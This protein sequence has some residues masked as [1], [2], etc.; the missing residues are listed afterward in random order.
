LYFVSI[1]LVFFMLNMEEE[2]EEKVVKRGRGRPRKEKVPESKTESKKVVLEVKA[3]EGVNVNVENAENKPEERAGAKDEK[4]ESKPKPKSKG[5]PKKK[6]GKKPRK[7]RQFRL[8]SRKVFLTY[9]KCF[10]SIDTVTDHL[11][12]L[13]QRYGI[14]GYIIAK[15][16][17]EDGSPHYHAL[18]SLFKKV[19][20]KRPDFFDLVSEEVLGMFKNTE[21]GNDEYTYKSVDYHGEYQG[22]KSEKDTLD[23]ITKE[24]FTAEETVDCLR[25]NEYYSKMMGGLYNYISLPK[26]MI[27]LAEQGKIDRAMSLLKT[28]DSEQ[29]LK[30]GSVIER[31]LMSIYLQTLGGVSK[32]PLSSFQGSPQFRSFIS[33]YE[34]GVRL[35]CPRFLIIKGPAGCGKSQFIR[36]FFEQHYGLRVFVVNNKEGL[37][38]FNPAIYGA[39]VYDDA[40]LRNENR[41]QMLAIVDFEDQ[42]IK[43]RYTHAFIPQTILKALLTNQPLHLVNTHL[44]SNDEAFKRRILF[45]EIGEDEK[46][47]SYR[48][49]VSALREQGRENDA[50]LLQQQQEYTEKVKQAQLEREQEKQARSNVSNVP[51]F[52]GGNTSPFPRVFGGSNSM[53]QPPFPSGFG[54]SNSM[55]QPPFP[56]GFGGSGGNSNTINVP[57]DFGANGGS[58][59]YKDDLSG[60]SNPYKPTPGVNTGSY[61]PNLN[62]ENDDFSEESFEGDFEGSFEEG[63]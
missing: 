31:R 59:D 1:F 20:I 48:A 62:V 23:Y 21:T 57:P 4:S 29:Y 55:N 54:G 12:L 18:F 53:N 7:P 37:K 46:L 24:K 41:E 3:E 10:M 6:F 16:M 39:L 15:E 22:V 58:R 38:G 40:D 35:G 2:K 33:L 34:E 26:R 51:P 25:C 8:A 11:N 14:E 9:P 45:I 60:G 36:S 56:S 49:T 28:E 30:A 5:R 43:I 44:G 61:N 50:Q 32:Y 52:P 27:Y 63:L 47:F 17:H 42:N 19:D 13:L